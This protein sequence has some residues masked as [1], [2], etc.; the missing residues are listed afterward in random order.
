MR[1]QDPESARFTKVYTDDDFINGVAE[2]LKNPSVQAV[3]VA[4]ILGCSVQYAKKCLKRMA[5]DGII[6][7]RIVGNVRVYRL[8]K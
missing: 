4:E 3:E 6:E 8:K 7:G 2:V 1:K 5:D